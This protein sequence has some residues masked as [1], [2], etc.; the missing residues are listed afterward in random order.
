MSFLQTSYLTQSKFTLLYFLFSNIFTK[1]CHNTNWLTL[2]SIL[3]TPRD[4]LFMTQERILLERGSTD[5][6]KASSSTITKEDDDID[7]AGVT[8][9]SDMKRRVYA[10]PIHVKG[11]R[12]SDQIESHVKEQFVF[13]Q[14]DS[15]TMHKKGHEQAINGFFKRTST[16]QSGRKDP[17]FSEYSFKQSM[18]S[19]RDKESDMLTS[20][21]LEN[22]ARKFDGSSF[23]GGLTR[24]TTPNFTKKTSAFG[25]EKKFSLRSS[26]DNPD[27]LQQI[28]S[29]ESTE[30]RG[31]KEHIT[32]DFAAVLS[33]RNKTKIPSLVEDNQLQFDRSSFRKSSKDIENL[34]SSVSASIKLDEYRTPDLKLHSGRRPI[35]RINLETLGRGGNAANFDQQLA[36][37]VFKTSDFAANITKNEDEESKAK[38]LERQ[39]QE[40][41]SFKW[42]ASGKRSQTVVQNQIGG[43]QESTNK[44]N[45]LREFEIMTPIISSNRIQT[46]GA[47]TDHCAHTRDSSLTLKI[48][49]SEPSTTKLH[50]PFIRRLDTNYGRSPKNS[51]AMHNGF[52]NQIKEKPYFQKKL[53]P[54]QLS[55]EAKFTKNLLDLLKD[56]P[57]DLSPVL[58]LNLSQK[59]SQPYRKFDFDAKKTMM[60]VE[61][62]NSHSTL[63]TNLLT[64][65]RRE[66]FPDIPIPKNLA[67]AQSNGFLRKGTFETLP[68]GLSPMAFSNRTLDLLSLSKGGFSGNYVH[69]PKADN[70]SMYD[71]R[72]IYA[73]EDNI[74]TIDISKYVFNYAHEDVEFNEGYKTGTHRSLIPHGIFSPDES[75]LSLQRDPSLPPQIRLN[76]SRNIIRTDSISSTGMASDTK[77]PINGGFEM[78]LQLEDGSPLVRVKTQNSLSRQESNSHPHRPIKVSVFGTSPRNQIALLMGPITI[79]Q[80]Q[81]DSPTKRN[82]LKAQSCEVPIVDEIAA[83]TKRSDE[84]IEANLPKTL[85]G[86]DTSKDIV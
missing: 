28:S 48:S 7:S 41:P 85:P 21:R 52:S 23:G 16:I 26:K 65:T 71:N 49:N 50:I 27:S 58:P 56:Q 61:S 30:L 83:Q 62:V 47:F 59:N 9:P 76:S 35:T 53:F 36:E 15:I 11:R 82:L 74:S 31:A 51:P 4:G 25:M 40:S 32:N 44:N 73:P 20:S 66:T 60:S 64:M 17:A 18:D 10:N 72:T 37:D 6:A 57:E 80:S 34:S 86:I 43:E 8:N 14:M 33:A 63:P 22:S 42:K 46:N 38:K 68:G 55:V 54:A 77:S 24:T 79:N 67:F 78:T 3:G 45:R 69:T 1:S 13:Y 81:P 75:Q 2:I 5:K 84:V 12:S 39:E 29:V 19:S 70:S